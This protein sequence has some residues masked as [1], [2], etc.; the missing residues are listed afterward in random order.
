M[1][2]KAARSLAIILT[3]SA[4]IFSGSPLRATETDDR[5]EA[6]AQNSYVFKTYLKNDS[7]KAASKDGVVTLTGTVSEAF[8]KSLAQ[9]TVEGLPTVKS[10]NNQLTVVADGPAEHTDKWLNQQVKAMLLFHHNVNGLNTEVSSEAG[11]VTLHGEASSAA[12]RDLTTEYANDVVGVKE[13]KNEMTI[14]EPKADS[15][16]TLG[17]V[18]D[19]ASVT[20]Q[21]KTALLVHRSTSMLKTHIETRDSKVTVSGVAKNRAEKALV[22]KLVTDVHGVTSVTNNMTLR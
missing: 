6:S 4:I 3:T 8:H 7:V 9:D 22:T 11:V 1:K 15:K 12:Q 17:E 20:A 10:V 5:I 14:T 21:V 18:I 16:R 13:V 19:D 2:N